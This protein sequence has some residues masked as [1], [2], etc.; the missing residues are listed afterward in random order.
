M[1]KGIKTGGRKKG[2]RNKS[3]NAYRAV[4]KDLAARG[5]ALLEAYDPIQKMIAICENPTA[6]LELQGKMN[7]EL[8]RYVHPQKRY[9]ENVGKDGGP[10]EI[11]VIRVGREKP[12][13]T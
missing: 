9:V 5:L 4:C 11:R 10:L 6:S 7:A 1:A 13:I 2:S 12:V 8:A 3:G